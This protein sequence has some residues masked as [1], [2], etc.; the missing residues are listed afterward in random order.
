VTTLVI[1]AAVGLG[2]FFLQKKKQQT[3]KKKNT[4]KLRKDAI[5]GLGI[6]K[7]NTKIYMYIICTR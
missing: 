6:K 4:F 1:L 7:K 5:L 2:F 3:N